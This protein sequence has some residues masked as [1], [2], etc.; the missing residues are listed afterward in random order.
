MNICGAHT[1]KRE[2]MNLYKELL[3]EG[4]LIET[5]HTREGGSIAK[6][7]SRTFPT[8]LFFTDSSGYGQLLLQRVLVAYAVHNKQIGYCQGMSFNYL[9]LRVFNLTTA[10]LYI[11]L[12][13]NELCSWSTPLLYARRRCIL[14]A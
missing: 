7:L 11:L 13:R 10:F 1:R 8:H 9:H 6:D 4:C 12:T 2:K 5:E 14:G 3:D